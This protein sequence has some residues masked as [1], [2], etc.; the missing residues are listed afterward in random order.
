MMI[1]KKCKS[2]MQWYMEYHFGQ[3][4]IGYKCGCCG[5]DTNGQKIV[6]DTRLSYLKQR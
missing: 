2:Y 5:Y 4:Y 3:P 1:C 6:C